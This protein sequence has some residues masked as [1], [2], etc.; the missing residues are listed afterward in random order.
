VDGKTFVNQYQYNALGTISQL[1][2]PS[3]TQVA[4]TYNGG[5]IDS[6]SINGQVFLSNVTYEPFG[7]VRS[8]QAAN[9]DVQQR[10]YD[11]SGRL[12]QITQGSFTKPSPTMPITISLPW[13]TAL[14]LLT[15]LTT[16]TMP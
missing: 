14:T 12:T 2:Y 15:T 16:A 8:W 1:T 3:G 5:N 10:Q 13:V 4:Y 7:G 6:V 11:T 9:G